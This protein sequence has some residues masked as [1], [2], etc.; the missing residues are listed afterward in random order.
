M[1]IILFF[2][3][4]LCLISGCQVRIY[5]VGN[6]EV[7]YSLNEHTC[8]VV[9]AAMKNENTLVSCDESGKLIEWDI[10][11]GRKLQVAFIIPSYCIPLPY[12]SII[13]SVL[14]SFN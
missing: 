8:N 1:R 4:F 12:E 3:R 2:D 9:G 11:T 6:G 10:V 13:F 7:I 14:G 5:N